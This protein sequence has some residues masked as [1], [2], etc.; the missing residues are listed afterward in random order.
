MQGQG[1]EDGQDLSWGLENLGQRVDLFLSPQNHYEM[2]W[3]AQEVLSPVYEG[4]G[5]GC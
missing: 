5:N 3:F 1:S 2:C 4:V